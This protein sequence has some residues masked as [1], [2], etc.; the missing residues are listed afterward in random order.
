M[1]R[2][3]NTLSN[4]EEDFHPIEEGAV[5]FYACGPTVYNYA[6]IGN[7]RTFAFKDLLCKY[8]RY[9]GYR[10]TQVMNITDVDD[11]TIQNARAQ[12]MTLK[13]YTAKYTEAFL[14]DC[15]TLRID[16]PDIMPRATEH[17]DEMVAL[18][19]TLDAKGFTYRKDGSVYFDIAKFQ[20]Y[21]KLSKAD[22]S[23]AQTGV[24]VDAD[25]YDKA[26]SRDF[27]LWKA[28]KE[29]EDFWE[30]EIGPGRPGWH[31]ECSAMSMKY[32]GETFDIHVGGIDL[33]FP[34][35][36][37]EIAQS[38]CATGKPFVRYWVHP[39]FLVVGGDKM[40]KSLGNISTLRDLLA[41]GHTP[42]AVRYLLLSVHYR[43]QL[44][45]T[46]D[47][48]R[49]AQASLQRLEDFVLRAKE[50]KRSSDGS[51]AAPSGDFAAE[52]SAARAKF[53]EAM[54]ADINASAAL[55]AVFD[56]VHYAY[57]KDGRGEFGAGEAGA[58][59]AFVEEVDSVF[60]ILR[61]QPELL[62]EEIAAQIEARQAARKRRDFAEADR[63]RQ[64]LL[65]QGIQLED[66]REGVRWKRM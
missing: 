26:N 57:Q 18:I 36:E 30:T 62:D 27:V 46:T 58:A 7:F 29:G 14:A 45:F 32:L 41:E 4:T 12:G 55:A 59:L 47:G 61:A 42:E 28:P 64:W 60:C 17:I 1:L 31:I 3:Y 11:K 53:R 21:G 13:D 56:F 22:F 16:P 39:E 37:N 48:L 33:V 54:D 15:K 10:V 43:K 6:H 40:S 49:A 20:G 25:Q 50:K 9:G 35:H 2:L 51:E 23:G 44:N 24:R 5:K 8:L 34:H 38:E 52:V 66:T 65:D 63:I 19:K